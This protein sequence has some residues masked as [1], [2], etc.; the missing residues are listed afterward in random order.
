V[1]LLSKGCNGNGL[2]VKRPRIKMNFDFFSKIIY[3]Y[4]NKKM[5]WFNKKLQYLMYMDYYLT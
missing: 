1:F 3:L 2:E 4:Q 5:K